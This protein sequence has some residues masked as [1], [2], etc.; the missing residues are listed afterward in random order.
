M[1][2]MREI[3][4]ATGNPGKLREIQAVLG[5]LPVAVKSLADFPAVD[6]PVEDGAT[7]AANARLKAHYYAAAFDTWCLADDSGLVVDALNGEPGVHSARYAADRVDPS[8]GRDVIDPANNA[9]LLDELADVPDDARTARFVCHLAL[10][11]S[12]GEI[13]IEA[14]GTIEGHI[15][16]APAGENGFG[17]DPLFRL[18]ALGCTTAEL[19]AE[20]KNAISHR[21]QATR[22]F[23]SLLAMLLERLGDG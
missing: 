4:V 8:A 17:Y 6:E 19:P 9:K 5:G 23:R 20:R 16:Y 12:A 21:G 13:L 2:T 14:S 15:G 3:V 10:A 1:N 18:P 7:F 22:Q 11:D